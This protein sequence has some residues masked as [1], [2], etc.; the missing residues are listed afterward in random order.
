MPDLCDTNILSAVPLALV[1]FGGGLWL[2]YRSSGVTR[3]RLTV[4]MLVA[5]AAVIALFAPPDHA[6]VSGS[7][8][9]PM[10]ASP[11]D[12]PRPTSGSVT[13]EPRRSAALE[14]DLG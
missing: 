1:L 7:D 10:A 13:D 12:S 5:A 14:C 2:L 3:E 9:A 8:P 6:G 4:L 11:A